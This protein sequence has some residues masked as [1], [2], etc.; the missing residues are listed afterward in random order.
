MAS[1]QILLVP[2]TTS[3]LLS[4]KHESAAKEEAARAAAAA[5]SDI[6]G[7]ALNTMMN[8]ELAARTAEQEVWTLEKP[9]WMLAP[10]QGWT[11]DQK[12]LASEFAAEQKRL[13]DEREKR[14]SS[15]EA[16]VS[17]PRANAHCLAHSVELHAGRP[18]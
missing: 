6:F 15:L 3:T 14:R 10:A 11:D 12:R 5:S 16:E 18:C 1:S 2:A 9:D 8:G 17:S 13:D 7:R 4:H